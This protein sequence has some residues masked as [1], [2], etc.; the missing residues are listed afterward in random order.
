[1]IFRLAAVRI[2]GR[3]P[4]RRLNFTNDFPAFVDEVAAVFPQQADRFR[5]L[6]ETINAF[7]ELDLSQEPVSARKVL[8]EHLSDPV[9]IDMLFCPLMFYGS[10]IPHDMDF[11]QFVIMFKSIFQQGSAGL[12]DGVRQILGGADAALQGAGGE[13]KLRH[14]VQ[15]SRSRTAGRS[16]VI[17]DDGR[18]IE[19][20][21]VL[22]SAGAAETVD[23]LAGANR[24]PSPAPPRGSCRSTRRSTSSTSSRREPRHTAKRS[25]STTIPSGSPTRSRTSRATSEPDRL[26]AEQFSV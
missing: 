7:D 20:D 15:E 11:S 21:N 9:L 8:Q 6:V 2:G 12:L 3:L 17:L 26:L 18:E 25:S 19:A 24:K 13:L 14:G 4:G 10:A 16:G 5:R 23:L 1:M 22:S